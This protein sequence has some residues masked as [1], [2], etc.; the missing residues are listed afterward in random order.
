MIILNFQ[1]PHTATQNT[2]SHTQ[3]REKTCKK[4]EKN[5]KRKIKCT[6]IKQQKARQ[7]ILLVNLQLILINKN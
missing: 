7:N 3:K 1:V 4:R 6:S 5:G 2:H